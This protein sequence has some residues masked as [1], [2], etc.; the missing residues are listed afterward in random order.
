MNMN[1]RDGTIST[2]LLRIL[3]GGAPLAQGQLAEILSLAGIEPS[4]LDR[5][6]VR[7]STERLAI[8]WT[9]MERAADDP[10]LGLHLGEL[11]GGLPSGHVLFSTM[12]NSPSL[13]Q[14]LER[15]CR[16]HDIMG[17]FL[18][19]RLMT[20]GSNTSLHVATRTGAP[21]H[22]QHVECVFC[23][24][25]SVL[26]YL[27]AA[28]FAGDVRFA[29]PRPADISEHLRIFG[30]ALRFAQPKSELVFARAY[31]QQPIVAADEELLGFLEQ[32]AERLLRRIRP[33][34]SWSDKVAGA[35]SQRLCDGTPRLRE[36]A[37]Q[38][39]VSQR[40]LQGKLEDEGTTFQRV[41]DG[42]RR[43]LATA[44]LE[45]DELSLAE[46]AFL[47]G[48]ADQSAF[49]HAFR[50]WTGDTPRRFRERNRRPA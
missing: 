12:L 6:Q 29:H 17:D 8:I 11:R 15:Y 23:L 32:Y 49:T 45:D 5:S 48:Y 41:L 50:R 9:E 16:L 42:V 47:L 27:S 33:A 19:P 40:S 43:Q 30:P 24:L 38:L 44:Y 2:D 10:N 26:S 13:G 28:R 7:I 46:I 4:L 36:V 18:Q 37:R 14:A 31:L 39:A 1:A 34:R 20:D 22:R 35:L 25:V 21:L 3:L